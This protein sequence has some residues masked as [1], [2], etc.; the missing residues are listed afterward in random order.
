MFLIKNSQPNC[1]DICKLAGNLFFLVGHF[2]KLKYV[3]T[4]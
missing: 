1:H 2:A 3:Y 4:T